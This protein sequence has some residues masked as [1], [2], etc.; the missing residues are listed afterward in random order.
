MDPVRS[1][2]REIRLVAFTEYSNPI[3]PADDIMLLK[4]GNLY[5][6]YN[7]AQS[8]NIETPDAYKDRV[9]IVE[10]SEYDGKSNMVAALTTGE[11]YI[12]ILKY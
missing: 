6:Q 9:T 5:I 2:S 4:M 7:R 1:G 10:A 12:H 3:V 11:R 8:Y